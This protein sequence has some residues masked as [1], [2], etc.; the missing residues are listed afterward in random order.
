MTTLKQSIFS[1]G[2]Q[3]GLI[4]GFL[5]FLIILLMPGIPSL[6]PEAQRTIAVAAWMIIWWVSEAVE[7][8]V[9]ALL[10]MICLPILG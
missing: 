6:S 8:P 1:W 3:I 5:V 4:S 10:P 9:T 2:R 7:L